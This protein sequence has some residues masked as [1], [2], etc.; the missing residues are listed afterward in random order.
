MYQL[1][2]G[3]SYKSGENVFFYTLPRE[4]LSISSAPSWDQRRATIQTPGQMSKEYGNRYDIRRS[5]L[6]G[7]YIQLETASVSILGIFLEKQ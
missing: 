1:K 6:I 3:S 2:R 4:L 5:T 7:A